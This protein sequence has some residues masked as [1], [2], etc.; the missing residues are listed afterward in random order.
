M[1]KGALQV[2]PERDLVSTPSSNRVEWI[3][4]AKGLAIILVVYGHSF[5]GLHAASYIESVSFLSSVDYIIYC[6]HMPLFFF[7]SGILAAGAGALLDRHFWIVRLRR[8]LWPY[9]FWMTVELILLSAFSGVTTMGHVT[10]G[11]F[12]Y[13]SNPISPFWFLYAL[14]CCHV[15]THVLSRLGREF[16]L[17]SALIVFGL[18]QFACTNELVHLVTW[19]LLWF[20]VGT[21][22]AS[23]VKTPWFAIQLSR[24][25]LLLGLTVSTVAL[26]LMFQAWNVPDRLN[27]PAA[28][29]GGGVMFCLAQCLSRISLRYPS[30]RAVQFLG[31][32][33]LTILVTHILGTAAT[34]II[35]ARVFAVHSI[36]LQL[37]AG[38]FVGLALPILVQ[39]VFARLGILR[40]AGLP[41]IKF[42][43]ARPQSANVVT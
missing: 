6:F 19:G 2:T 16:L 8:I 4:F 40:L 37:F 7:L 39:V 29:T 38:V 20:V 22:S 3:D 31:L 33:S 5:R 27:I 12:T 43:W 1:A 41:R 28:I 9:V 10:F 21:I 36:W 35:L 30:V 42:S 34:R 11:V 13:L 15:F 26:G 18:G 24:L 25:S 32:A 23:T 17:I 14:C